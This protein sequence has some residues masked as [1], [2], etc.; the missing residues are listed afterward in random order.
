MQRKALLA[1]AGWVE[2]ERHSYFVYYGLVRGTHGRLAD[3]LEGL[4][5]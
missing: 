2:P 3:A 4:L 1:E 5:G